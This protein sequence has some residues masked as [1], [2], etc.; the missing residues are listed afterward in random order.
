[1]IVAARKA[2]EALTD[3]EQVQ[4]QILD[5][6]LELDRPTFEEIIKVALDKTMSV[7]KRVMRDAKLQLDD[8]QNV[9]LV[10]APPAPM[11]YKNWL[12]KYSSKHHC[13]PSTRMKL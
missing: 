8:I 1:M 11:P 12:Q 4:L 7:C 2:K 10:G 9:V 6:T 3:A 13:V 5:Q